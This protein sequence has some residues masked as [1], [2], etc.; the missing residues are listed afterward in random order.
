MPSREEAKVEAQLV[1]LRDK[2][3]GQKLML[4]YFLDIDDE[5]AAADCHQEIFFL[6]RRIRL[7]SNPTDVH[8]DGEDDD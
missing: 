1:I 8:A 2:L 3:A 4:E 7:I 5:E 6:E